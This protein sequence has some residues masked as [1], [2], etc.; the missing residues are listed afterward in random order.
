MTQPVILVSNTAWYLYNFRRGTLAELVAKGHRVVALAPPDRYA[1]KL[2]EELGV[3]FVP[4][5]L[6][7]KGTGPVGEARSLLALWSLLRRLRPGFVFNFTVKANIYSG[8]VCRLLR[9][10]YANNVSGLGTAFL[11]DTWLYRRV[12]SLYA[13][14]NRRAERVFFQ[15]EEDL[16]TF[17]A[18]GLLKDTPTVLLPG[19]GMDTVRFPFSALPSEGPFTFVMVARLIGDKGVREYVAAAAQVARRHRDVRFLLIG[20]QGVSNSSAIPPDE[21]ARWREA[22]VV[23]YLGEQDDV[24]PFIAESHVLVLP[25]YREGMPRTVLEAASMGRPAIVTDVPGCRQAVVNGET[26]WLCEV[27][28]AESLAACMQDCL[29]LSPETLASAGQAARRRIEAE[30][31]ERLV[32]RAALDCLEGACP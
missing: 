20:P 4:L 12:R 25:S 10:P 7:G 21:V 19:S 6:D 2:V 3:E 11:Y 13:F 28:S 27:K 5:R 14:A 16:G 18:T 30:F 1:D 15:N 26:G 29:A 31:D 17:Q 32:V 22:G 23:E 24:R 9:I 8:L